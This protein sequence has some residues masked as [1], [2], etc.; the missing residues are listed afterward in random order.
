MLSPSVPPIIRNGLFNSSE[1]IIFVL[2]LY[3]IVPVILEGI[4]L[5]I[6]VVR[7]AYVVKCGHPLDKGSRL[8]NCLNKCKSSKEKIKQAQT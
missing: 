2:C 7:N 8:T 5:N 6:E 4:K 3:G 1:F